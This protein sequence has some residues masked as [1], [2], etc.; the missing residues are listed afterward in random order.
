MTRARDHD[1]PSSLFN[2]HTPRAIHVGYI[3]LVVET[4]RGEG[5]SAGVREAAAV[6][7]EDHPT[8][9]KLSERKALNP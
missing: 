3:I 1:I 8:V 2:E 7:L 9:R 6:N 5:A 4:R